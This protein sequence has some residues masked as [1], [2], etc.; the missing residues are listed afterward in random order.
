MPYVREI[1]PEVVRLNGFITRSRAI[2]KKHMDFGP[3]PGNIDVYVDAIS[4]KADRLS[5]EAMKAWEVDFLH[6]I[7]E[8]PPHRQRETQS[9]KKEAFS[10][11]K[12]TLIQRVLDVVHQ[13]A[14]RQ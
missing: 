9:E 4:Q 2:P 8:K 6:A 14:F 12:L 5:E 13:L 3:V 10:P 7:K 1:L 11:A